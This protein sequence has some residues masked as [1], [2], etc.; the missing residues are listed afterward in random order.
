[1][2]EIFRI[3]NLDLQEFIRLEK[4]IDEKSKIIIKNFVNIDI[5]K[6]INILLL[7][8][9]FLISIEID[10]YFDYGKG[11]NIVFG[12]EII[13]YLPNVERITVSALNGAEVT[14]IDVFAKVANL[15]ECRFVGN[16]KK[17]LSLD[18]LFNHS[19]IEYFEMENGLSKKQQEIF[20]YLSNL[21]E[22]RISNL[23]M[24]KCNDMN[25]LEKIRIYNDIQCV[26]LMQKKTGNLKSL[27]LEKCKSITDIH[28]INDFCHLESLWL[29]YM[30]QIDTLP[31]LKNPQKMRLFQ[32]TNAKN[33]KNIDSLFEM[34]NLQG[35]MLTDLVHLKAD[36]FKE[37]SNLGK[38]KAVL[39]TF[40][41]HRENEK[42][43]DFII[44]NN[45][46]CKQPG[47]VLN[48]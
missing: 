27:Y 22:I 19:N 9:K 35:V 4:E 36:D 40:K 26:N 47:L 11:D 3:T 14:N 21:K 7:K 44:S 39:I 25:F 13:Q 37:L 24:S 20:N 48:G 23:D 2:N 34:E 8:I 43:Y 30:K 45:W 15:K 41:D 12:K 6:R 18:P 28:F 46:E 38:L 17:G 31:K 5:L 32:I 29:R 33:I 1:M 42:I 16:F 10:D